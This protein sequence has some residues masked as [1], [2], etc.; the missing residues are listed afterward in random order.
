MARLD[1]HVDPGDGPMFLTISTTHQPATDL[2]YL[3]YKHPDRSQT[4]A[5]TGGTAHVFYPQADDARCTAALLVDINPIALVRRQKSAG[6]GQY[7]NDRPY[8]ASSLLSV[9][10]SRVFRTALT[11]RCDARPE[12]AA[13]PIPLDIHVPALPCHGEPELVEQFFA[14][15]G[16]TVTA[17]VVPLDPEI[18]AWTDASYVDLHLTGSLRL[19]DALS[20]LYVLLPALD[21][22][23]HYWVGEDEVD[24]LLRAGSGW[25]AAHPAR[26]VISQRYLAHRRRYVDAA[27]ERLDVPAVTEAAPEP[28]LAAVRRAAVAEE[29]ATAGVHTVADIGCGEGALLAELRRNSVYRKL[30]GTDVSIAALR[31]A[32]NRLRLDQAVDQRIQLFQSS[33]V[34][35]DARLDEVDAAVLM[36]VIEH[37]DPPRLTALARNVFGESAPKVVIVTTPNADYNVRYELE[38]F[39]HRDHRFEW[40][41]PEFDGWCAHVASRFGYAVRH[42]GVGEPDP[43]LGSSTQLAVFTKETA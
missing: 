11:G 9:A 42:R 30:I 25:L 34:Y 23:K 7:V 6:L 32:N 18:P 26:E 38:G 14:P 2:G 5:V 8:A 29:L 41:R 40:T 20:H 36:E 1:P 13:Q 22:D 19:A 43:A 33:V 35:R 4:F 24:K 28:P 3:L 39:R 16:W 27:L 21:D 31:R 10:L 17:S 15:L 37:V 12:L